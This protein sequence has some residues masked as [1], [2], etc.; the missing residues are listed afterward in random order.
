L[1][2]ETAGAFN[3]LASCSSRSIPVFNSVGT[4]IIPQ[5]FSS[6]LLSVI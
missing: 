4:F 3:Y 2:M 6:M 1:T 5:N